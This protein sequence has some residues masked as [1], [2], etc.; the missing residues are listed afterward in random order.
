MRRNSVAQ[1]STVNINAKNHVPFTQDC[2]LSNTESKSG[3][4]AFF[5][6]R[7]KRRGFIV[8]NC[9]GDA[10]A[11]IVINA[12]RYA[13]RNSGIVIVATDDTDAAV[14]LVHHWE[15]AMQDIYFFEE[16]WNKA[17]SI[18]DVC[19]R[20]IAIKEHLL[21]LHSWS[22]CDSTSVVFGKSKPKVA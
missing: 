5:S 11:S 4:I 20:N 1:S 19:T 13:K 14:M 18:K 6:F 17:W 12:L 9:S 10:D 3:L 21:F 2:F 15:V 22:G 7:L 16:R 8:I